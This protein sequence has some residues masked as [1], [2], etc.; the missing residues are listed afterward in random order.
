MTPEEKFQYLIQST[1]ENSKAREV[2]ESF[3]P[4]AENY[5]KAIGYMKERFG[6]DEVLVEV[7][8][9]ELLRLVLVNAT[10]PKEQS[11][12]LC[13]YDK[14]ETQLRALE[15]LGVT[16]DKF[17][18]MLYPLVES[19]LPEEVMRTWERNRG[20]IAMQPDASKDRLALLMTFLKGEVDGE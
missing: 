11:S 14:L 6:K 19:C 3:P 9:R 17:A 1:L 2:V 7:Y 15:T 20:Q 18:A 16:S 5:T 4:T 10:N 13:M 12:V 8:V